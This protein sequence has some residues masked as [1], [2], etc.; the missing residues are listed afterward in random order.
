VAAGGVATVP[1]AALVRRINPGAEA[2][3]GGG[4]P[5]GLPDAVGAEWEIVAGGVEN[6]ADCE[7]HPAL[8]VTARRGRNVEQGAEEEPSDGS[9]GKRARYT[10]RTQSLFGFGGSRRE[11]SEVGFKTRSVGKA[12]EAG[13][14]LGG[15][16]GV[17]LGCEGLVE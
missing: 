14:V 10:E 4:S 1:C 17:E 5:R 2:A 12:R 7:V 8:Q 11:E 13:R 15:G 9:E 3:C 6:L 16:E